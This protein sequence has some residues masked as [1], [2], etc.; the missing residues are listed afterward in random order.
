MEGIAELSGCQTGAFDV[1][2]IGFVDDNAI[3]H[4]HDTTLDALQL[5]TRTCQLDEQ[6]EINHRMDGRLALSY[7]HGL[8]KNLVIA[9]SFAKDNGFAR[10][11]CHSSQRPR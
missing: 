11:A 9:G 10:L 1:V 4:L 5:V 8:D 6:E 2:A 7:A 3:G